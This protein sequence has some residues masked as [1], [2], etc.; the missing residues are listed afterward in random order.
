MTKP[1][2]PEEFFAAEVPRAKCF[3]CRLSIREEM[4]RA[5]LA[6]V[7]LSS[8]ARWVAAVHPDVRLGQSAISRHFSERHHERNTSV[9]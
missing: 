7:S 3:L 2:S 4:E 6:G 5:R 1:V 9:S 8:L